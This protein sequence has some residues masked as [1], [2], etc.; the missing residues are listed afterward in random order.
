MFSDI[1]KRFLKK[2]EEG[3]YEGVVSLLTLM[4]LT[5]A[6]RSLCVE[7]MSEYDPENWKQFI[8]KVYEVINSFKNIK[9][10]EGN[11]SER[12]GISMIRDILYSEIVKEAHNILSRHNGKVFVNEKG[13]LTHS[14]INCVDSL[15]I[16]LARKTGCGR[17]ATFDNGFVETKSEMI[18]LMLQRDLW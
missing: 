7:L 12:V 13:K 18:P 5:K 2:I 14:G 17:I 8:A 15:H 4:E 10:V 6:V 16:I 11:P 3:K 9:I 1:A